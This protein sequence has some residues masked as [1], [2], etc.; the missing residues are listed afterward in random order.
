MRAWMYCAPASPCLLVGYPIASG[1]VYYG[2]FIVQRPDKPL[3]DDA[4]RKLAQLLRDLVER[5]YQPVLAP[6]TMAFTNGSWGICSTR[7]RIE[8]QSRTT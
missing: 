6:A 1:D 2:H 4:N 5:Y 8:G 3:S 7:G